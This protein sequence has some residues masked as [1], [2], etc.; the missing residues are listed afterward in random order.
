MFF[1]VF[2]YVYGADFVDIIIDF[3]Q[4]RIIFL[5]RKYCTKDKIKT[6]M[7]WHIHLWMFW[8]CPLTFSFR[9]M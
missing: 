5:W 1:S 3:Y 2:N 6:M 4:S 8:R 7:E 9:I